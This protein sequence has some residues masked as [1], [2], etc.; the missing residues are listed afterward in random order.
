MGYPGLSWT[1]GALA[2]GCLVCAGLGRLRF[3]LPK[4]GL[5]VPLSVLDMGLS[6]HRLSGQEDGVS[7]VVLDPVFTRQ[8]GPGGF[9]ELIGSLFFNYLFP[10]KHV[11]VGR[12]PI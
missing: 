12:L 9:E 1:C 10:G 11:G 4:P 7:G 5:E 8:R 2:L 6:D 3:G